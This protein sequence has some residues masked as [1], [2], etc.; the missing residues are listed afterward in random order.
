[1]RENPIDPHDS[2]K[3]K[4]DVRAELRPWNQRRRQWNAAA[5]KESTCPTARLAVVMVFSVAES[6]PPRNAGRRQRLMQ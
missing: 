1:M 4:G 2:R 3:R 5:D 6:K